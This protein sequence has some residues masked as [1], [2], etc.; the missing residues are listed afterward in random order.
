M[1]TSDSN[2]TFDARGWCDYCNNFHRN[3]LPNWHPDEIGARQLERDAEAMQRA[4]R[5]R[6]HDCVI[7]IS[8]GVDSSYV[9]YLAKEKLGLRPLLLHVD[10]GWNS[11]QAVNNI[12]K[13]VDGLGLDLHTEVVDWAE[14]RDLQLAFFK[15]QVPHLDTPQD[16]AFFAGL[17]NF[18]AK[19]GVKYILTG[20]NYSTECVREPLEWHYH[21]SDLRQLKDIH[22]RFGTRPLRT[23]P[24][25]DILTFKVYY[26]FL[27]GVRVLKPL[28]NVRYIKEEAMQLL[29]DRFGWQRYAH[30]H[31]ESRFTRFY[32]GYWLPRKFGYD[33]RRAHFS[34][35]IL[36]KQMTR[37]EALQKISQP[38]Y[39]D[40]TIAHD[41][42]YVATKLDIS[43]ETLREL[44]NG[45]NKT[46]RDYKHSMAVINIGTQALRLAG[47]QRAIIR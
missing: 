42:E 22:R 20:A 6:D 23:F 1:D 16:H 41:F 29:V 26:R 35:L 37:D 38:A 46:Y 34:S 30:K 2:I 43:V 9:T 19:H 8:G 47:V 40:E 15:A 24:T 31:Y 45:P 36:T 33:K 5:G 10:A 3:I 18:A 14:M 12:E 21:A 7:G 28:N 11:Q 27:K 25:A 44:M 32:E 4:G 17:Y 13:L 39:D